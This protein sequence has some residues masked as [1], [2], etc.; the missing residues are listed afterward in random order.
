MNAEE[1]QGNKRAHGIE[2]QRA[3]LAGAG[4]VFSRQAYSEARLKDIA[5]E[6]EISQGSLYFHYGNKDDIARAV[7]TAQQ[8]RMNKVLQE[9]RESNGTA[10]EKLVSLFG[11]LAALV[12]SDHLVQGGIRLSMQPDAEIE[13]E[14]KGPYLEWIRVASALIQ[15]GLEDGSLSPA[16]DAEATAEILNELFIGAQVLSG[17][18]DEWRSFP[19]RIERLN[20]VLVLILTAGAAAGT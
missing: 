10:L 13:S 18:D 7:L 4:R 8:E 14:A 12:A 19:A 6:A 9:A 17:I 15:S 2:T 16:A 1:N 3:I 20:P 11:R 5:D